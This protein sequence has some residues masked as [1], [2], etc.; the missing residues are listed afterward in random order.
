M[1]LSQENINEIIQEKQKIEVDEQFLQNIK[2]IID[3]V[4]TRIHWKSEELLPV[5][6]VL[7]QIDELLE[8]K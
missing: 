5:G 3:I 2:G 6:I 8:K 7:K 4:T 1:S